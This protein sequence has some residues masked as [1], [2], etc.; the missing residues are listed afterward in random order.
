MET[1]E[2]WETCCRKGWWWPAWLCLGVRPC[3]GIRTCTPDN[4]VKHEPET[5]GQRH[6]FVWLNT[7][8]PGHFA[9]VFRPLCHIFHHIDPRL[10]A[11]PPQLLSRCMEHDWIPGAACAER[12]GT[13]PCTQYFGDR[14]FCH[15]G[16]LRDRFRHVLL[17]LETS[18]TDTSLLSTRHKGKVG[19]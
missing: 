4:R 12:Q 8:A 5:F 9:S 11:S 2:K 7:C 18:S 17:P 16:K 10:R 3:T 14:G 1:V 13:L 19:Q 15:S 6:H